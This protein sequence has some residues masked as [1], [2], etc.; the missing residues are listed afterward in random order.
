MRFHCSNLKVLGGKSHIN[1]PFVKGDTKLVNNLAYK[2]AE[3]T[4]IFSFDA[5]QTCYKFDV[6][7]KLRLLPSS[8]LTWFAVLV[9]RCHAFDALSKVTKCSGF[10]SVKRAE[11]GGQF[12]KSP[13]NQSGLKSSFKVKICGF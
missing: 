12:F 10:P 7:N 5:R 13:V 4:E 2:G 6:Q 3:I 9:Q 8:A 11:S 1:F